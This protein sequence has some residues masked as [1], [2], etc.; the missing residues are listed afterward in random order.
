MNILG[1]HFGHDAS[2]T[3]VRDG[4]IEAHV[5][6]E[7]HNRVKHSVGLRADEIDAALE[8]SGLRW[9]DID[10]CALVSTQDL[11]IMSGLLDDFS[12]EPGPTPQHPVE[13]PFDTLLRS[14]GADVQQLLV[15]GLHQVAQLDERELAN[16][17]NSRWEKI[18]PEWDAFRAGEIASVGWLNLFTTH[19]RWQQKRGLDQIR[20]D[21]FDE[22]LFGDATRLGMH[23][24]VTVSWR[25]HSLPGY[26]VDHHICHAASAYYR[27]GFSDSAIITHDGGDAERNLSGLFCYGRDHRLYTLG[28]HHLALGGIYRAI[29]INLGFDA[30]GPEGKLMG[31][32]SYGS[33]RFF[34]SRFVGNI[35]DIGKRFN[36]GPFSAW[37]RHCIDRAGLASYDMAHGHADQVLEPLSI[38]IAASTQKLFEEGYLLAAEVLADGLA[39]SGRPTQQLCLSGGAALNCPGNSRLH[40]ESAYTDIYIDPNCDDGGL[41][42]GGALFIAH[43]LLEEPLDAEKVSSNRSP[44]RGV[45]W[46]ATLSE[47][48]AADAGSDYDVSRP[49]Q[50]AASA[51]QDLAD[52]Q[53]I[54]FFEGRSEMG[55]RAL[56]HRSVLALPTDGD[57]WVRVNR[58]KGREGW[59][60]FAPVV[61]ESKMTD[62]FADCPTHSPYMLFTARVR[63]RLLPAITHVDGSSRIQTVT[64]ES[65]TIH[66]ILLELDALTGVPVLMNTS[67][68]GPGVPIVERPVE[69]Y[70]LFCE[71]DVD[72]LY[73]DG[74]R[75]AKRTT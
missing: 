69:A 55:P 66:D 60:P 50:P 14:A 5:L 9:K 15:K 65:G 72:V 73:L 44:F 35:H 41:S 64:A 26:F 12:I 29:G 61:P 48:I 54:A 18:F 53:V 67:L 59:R 47:D 38:D 4:N 71:R 45:S 24:P 31:L 51:A 27:S 23:Y 32:S 36:E 19:E 43:N 37:Y 3:V 10:L 75:I 8:Q 28:P 30:I 74:I 39:R 17:E 1:L 16:A 22:A 57:N 49:E 70:Q 21:G 33:P 46:P 34:D 11:E 25:G 52:N 6:A 62:W 2:V 20:A 13:S 7:R 68:N 56:C 42:V 63:S 40:N 58:I